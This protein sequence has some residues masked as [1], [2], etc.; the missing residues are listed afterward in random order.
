MGTLESPPVLGAALSSLL[1]L[2]LHETVFGSP[3]WRASGAVACVLMI[4]AILLTLTRAAWLSIFLGAAVLG[5]S[6]LRRRPVVALVLLALVAAAMVGAPALIN[7]LADD[8]R[9]RDDTNATGRLETSL[10]SW[11]Q[12]MQRPLFGWGPLS[13]T[14]FSATSGYT[15]WVSHN[16]F[17]SLL[18]AT[19]SLGMSLYLVPAIVAVVRGCFL[20]G[21]LGVE[22]ERVRRFALAGASAYVVNALAIDMHYFSFPHTLFWL[23]L[24]FLLTGNPSPVELQ[25]EAA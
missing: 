25:R 22:V 15:E 13:F 4:A 8:P 14:H 19:G 18:V 5:L 10:L 1:F 11:Q 12:F 24:G 20:A 17:M 16:T 6:M 7:A 2:A 23:C 21:P 9:L 3:R